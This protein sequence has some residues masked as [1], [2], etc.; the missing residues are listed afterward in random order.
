MQMCVVV[1]DGSFPSATA[2][3][4]G[5]TEETARRAAE[6]GFDSLQLTVNRPSEVDVRAV[7]RAAD[8]YGLKVVS[9]ATGRGYTVDGLSLGA[10]DEEN[11][12][13]AVR[14]MK[15]HVELSA[16][17]GNPFVVAGAIRG[18]S[19]DSPSREI[20][21]GQFTRSFHELLPYAERYGVTVIL[22][23]SDH[24][25]TDMYLDPIET[26]DY[27]RQFASPAFR[28]HVDTMNLWNEGIG[29]FDWLI[30]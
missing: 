20:Y 18:R 10:G 25:E 8:A 13:S 26:A 9:L 14:R 17:R 16:E 4:Q 29:T 23:A 27:V 6:I 2:P 5:T 28:L 7:R 12:R 21:I 15:E 24:L 30:S 3:L 1:A 19:S 11:R 22:E